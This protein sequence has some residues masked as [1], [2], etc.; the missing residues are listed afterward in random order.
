MQSIAKM[1]VSQD[2]SYMQQLPTEILIIIVRELSLLDSVE[3]LSLVNQRL[4]MI[5]SPYLFQKLNIP[6]SLA[7]LERLRQISSSPLATHVRTLRYD[8]TELIE[9]R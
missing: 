4:R 7:G 1:I 2:P 9:P 3:C 8:P 5:C 6:F